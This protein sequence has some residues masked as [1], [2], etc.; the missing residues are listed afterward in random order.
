MIYPEIQIQK[1]PEMSFAGVVCIF[2]N[3]KYAN[4]AVAY[5]NGEPTVLIS[6]NGSC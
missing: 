4:Q 5:E 3:T 6:F 2:E 1:L